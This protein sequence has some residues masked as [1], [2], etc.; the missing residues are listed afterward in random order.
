MTS[1]RFA[2]VE[3]RN[4]KFSSSMSD[5]LFEANSLEEL[6]AKLKTKVS[7]SD[8]SAFDYGDEDW[9]LGGGDLL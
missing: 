9:V 1:K 4:S 3:I 5:P 7:P 6:E 8:E 2:V